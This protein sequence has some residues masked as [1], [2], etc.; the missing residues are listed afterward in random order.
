MVKKDEEADGVGV[1][2]V[3]EVCVEVMKS[4]DSLRRRW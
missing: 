1:G 2:E 4:E 3:V